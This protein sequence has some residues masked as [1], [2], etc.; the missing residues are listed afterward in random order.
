MPDDNPAEPTND[1][2]ALLAEAFQVPED[3]ITNSTE[4]GDLPEWDSMGHMNMLASLEARFGLE[5]N[6][7]MI[8]RLTS[9]A[10]ISEFLQEAHASPPG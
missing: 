7:E 9:V 2:Q 5:V 3:Q 6:A 4:F 1:V 8:T 10:A